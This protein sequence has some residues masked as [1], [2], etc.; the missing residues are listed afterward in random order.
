[1]SKSSNNKGLS[2]S[3]NTQTVKTR[4]WP[5]HFLASP[6]TLNMEDVR[7]AKKTLQKHVLSTIYGKQ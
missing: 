6:T 7:E 1:M 2:Q 3:E 5:G 4:V